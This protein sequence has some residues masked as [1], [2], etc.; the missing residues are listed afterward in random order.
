LINRIFLICI[1][2]GS[3]ISKASADPSAE[4][5][6]FQMQRGYHHNNFELSLVHILQNNIEPLRL[7][8][9]WHGHEEITHLLSLSG[10]AVEYLSKNQQVTFAES[11]DSAY[12]LEHSHLPGLWFSILNCSPETLLK[13]YEVVSTGKN[14]IAGQVVQQIRLTP[15]ADGKYSFII[16]LE[17]K[18]GVLLRLDI[19]DS[20]GILMEQYLGVDFHFLPENSP[21]I[22]SVA[23]MKVP[24]AERSQ[25]IYQAE[26]ESHKWKLGWLPLGFSAVSSDRHKLIGDDEVMDY[27]LLSDGLVD[28]SVYL[29]RGQ[30]DAV[31]HEKE[32]FAMHGATSILTI[33]RDD[34]VRLTIVGELP[35]A[36][37]HRI[38]ES[39]QVN[40]KETI[41]D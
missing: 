21:V 1:L 36:S 19:S 29:S 3:S 2:I 10:R 6:L 16:W 27:F 4:A 9:G 37:L 8:H 15:K 22:K 17:Q 33:T 28:V 35:V 11:A 32:Q 18:T 14:R 23:S 38:A 5:L 12:T 24:S 41:N 34:G 26:S 30:S 25:D 31:S 7:I 13:Y 40:Q 20:Q 39:I